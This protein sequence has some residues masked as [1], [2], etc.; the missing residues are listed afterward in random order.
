MTSFIVY[1]HSSYSDCWDAFFGRSKRYFNIP[2]DNYYI[3]TDSV[4]SRIDDRF[5]TVLYDEKF[6]YT[7]RLFH[8]L[9]QISDDYVFFTHEDMILY[10]HV[11][12]QY[13]EECLDTI[14]DVDFIKLLKGGGAKDLEVDTQYQNSEVLKTAPFYYE[15]LFAIQP[16]LW[17]RRSFINLLANNLNQSIW[18]FETKGQE[19]C[20]Q[21]N[22][23]SLYAYASEVDKKRGAAH[24]DSIT[25]PYIATA[26]FKGKWT[27]GQYPKELDD[28]AIE[29]NIDMSIR[30]CI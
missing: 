26:I 23:Q 17:N 25:Y 10:D 14:K 11:H 18:D 19:F 8:C 28:L 24:Y 4:N 13:M 27:T 22:F 20:R 29:F 7:N 21:N 16:S 30:G 12:R 3:F 15:F 1:S 9:N 5:Q 6:Y 2:F